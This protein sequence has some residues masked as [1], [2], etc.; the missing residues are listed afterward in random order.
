MKLDSITRMNAADNFTYMTI[1][2]LCFSL[3][4]CP[5]TRQ[6][7][8][9]VIH[10]STGLNTSGSVIVESERKTLAVRPYEKTISPLLKAYKIG[11][12]HEF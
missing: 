8:G 6:S 7:A 4:T 9:W 3:A 11:C 10:E 5:D 2:E 12:R 1:F